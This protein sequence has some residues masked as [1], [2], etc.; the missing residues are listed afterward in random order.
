MEC[1]QCGASMSENASRCEQCAATTPST[2]STS[3]ASPV[4][5]QATPAQPVSLPSVCPVVTPPKAPPSGNRWVKPTL[6][7]LVALL[8]LSVAAMA[9]VHQLFPSAVP[10]D[11][12]LP[13]DTAAVV[14]ADTPWWWENCKVAREQPQTRLAISR[15]E[16]AMGISL[17]SDVLPWAGQFGVAVLDVQRA[18]PQLLIMLEI[19]DRS[20]FLKAYPQLLKSME[21]KSDTVWTDSHYHGVAIREAT[22]AFEGTPLK[23]ASAH[24]AGWLVWSIGDGVM[25]KSIDAAKEDAA[26]LQDNTAWAQDITQIPSKHIAFFGFNGKPFGK[27]MGNF[28]ETAGKQFATMGMDSLLGVGTMNATPRGLR[29]DTVSTVGAGQIQTQWK[30]MKS[31][32]GVSGASLPLLPEGTILSLLFSNPGQVWS[33]M[34]HSMLS[35]AEGEQGEQMEKLVEQMKP[36]DDILQ[37]ISGEAAL[38]LCW[39]PAHGFGL[40]LLGNTD[41]ASIAGQQATALNTYLLS[42]RQPVASH[43]GSFQLTLPGAQ[44]AEFPTQLSWAAKG[45]WF[46]L[47]TQPA[48]LNGNGQ[49]L[50]QFPPAAHGADGAMVLDLQSLPALA[51]H[52]DALEGNH[53]FSNVVNELELAKLQIVS[54][55]LLDADCLTSR[56]TMEMNNWP[57]QNL[58]KLGTI[59]PENLPA[60]PGAVPPTKHVRQF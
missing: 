24:F 47:S 41:S 32:H 17:E 23:V 27:I 50:L 60:K 13:A 34:E 10:I 21:Q 57:W 55:S 46:K 5:P 1:P 38:A 54:Y 28:N 33:G 6:I 52:I 31:A 58:F 20:A 45:A 48:Y 30:A 15:L 59:I 51:K 3:S 39:T 44:S 42:L 7:G 43:A 36:V 16:K 49:T 37:H 8:V 35:S 11:Q 29:M 22:V 19:R 53:T 26:S 14:S 40:V 56:G 9:I 2:E 18:S 25:Q 12:L 4:I